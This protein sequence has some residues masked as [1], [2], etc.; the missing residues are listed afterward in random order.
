MRI[1]RDGFPYILFFLPVGIALIAAG[2]IWLG[3]IFIGLGLFVAFF[4]RDPER[5]FNGGEKSVIS[6]ADGKVVAVK[7]DSNGA[8]ISIFLS[9]FN[10]HINRSPVAGMVSRVQYYTGKFMGAFYEKAST[11]NERNLI[12]IEKPDGTTVT[13]VQIAG[14]VARRIVCWKKV[15]EPVQAGERVGLIK[16]GSRVDVFFPPGSKLNVKLKD[17]VRAGHT[18]IGE[19]P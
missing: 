16:F 13:F 12:T 5:S 1:A 11:E 19:L 8:A 9:V 6:P 15:G 3:I 18:I 7:E 10:V 4:F 14:L 2:Y 17:K